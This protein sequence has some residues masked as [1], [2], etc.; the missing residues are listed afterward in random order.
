MTT[1]FQYPAFYNRY[2]IIKAL[3]MVNPR[4]FGLEMFRFPMESLHHYVSYDEEHSLPDPSFKFYQ[5]TTGKILLDHVSDLQSDQGKPRKLALQKLNLVRGFHTKNSNVFRFVEAHF[6][7]K[8]PPQ[9]LEVLNYGLLNR[10]Y[11]YPKNPYAE[12]QR[13]H[14][15]NKTV[16]DKI[17][18]V[19]QTSSRNNFL[20]YEV[21]TVL[22]SL[23]ALNTAKKT[24]TPRTMLIL[25]SPEKLLLLDIWKW[26][27][28]DFSEMSPISAISKDHLSKVN[29]I[30]NFNN[31]WTVLNLGRL[32][33]WR[34]AGDNKTGLKPAD[35]Q[36]FFLRLLLG[37]SI[38]GAVKEKPVEGFDSNVVDD[39]RLNPEL[40]VSD[41]ETH[42]P[43]E[44]GNDSL[45]SEIDKDLS[46]LEELEEKH[47][48]NK[49]TI[50]ESDELA[51]DDFFTKP[52]S[53]EEHAELTKSIFGYKEPENRLVEK[54]DRIADL[55]I[56]SAGD[57]RAAKKQVEKVSSI[58]N[59]FTKGKSIV[60]FS[61]IAK[62]ELELDTAKTKING[63][64][65]LRDQSMTESSLRSF[66]S[67]YIEKV[68]NKDIAG[69]ILNI[70]NSGVMILNH[71][72]ETTNSVLGGYVNHT[73]HIKPLEGVSSVIRFRLPV[74]SDDGTYKLSGNKCYMRKQ[75]G[76]LPIRKMSP[77]SVALTSYYGKVFV[78]RST[79]KV[80]DTYDWLARKIVG[81][82]ETTDSKHI[83][84]YY[85]ANV[86]DNK[87]QLPKVYSSLAMHFKALKFNNMTIEFDRNERYETSL[88]HPAAPLF[89]CGINN[90][91]EFILVGTDNNFYT[92]RNNKLEPLG[93]IFNICLIDRVLAPVETANINIY[94]KKVPLGIA[95]GYYLGLHKLIRLLKC[96]IRVVGRRE[97][98]NL[99]QN[100]YEIVFNDK[101]IIADRN[102]ATTSLLLS[103]FDQYKNT[104]KGYKLSEF[105]S[106]NIYLNLLES[107]GLSTRIIRE[108]DTLDDLFV[109]PITKDILKEMSEPE[110]FIGLL[111]RSAELLTTDYHPDE[112]GM[113]HMRI[114]GYERFAG[115][116]YKE[117]VTSIKEF[118][119][120]G[121]RG[122]TG[123][124][125]NPHAVLMTVARDQSASICQDINPIN[126]LKEQEAVTFAGEGG[127]SKETMTRPTR[128]FDPSDCDII[129]EASVDSSD[130][131]INSFMSNNPQFSSLR[132][133]AKKSSDEFKPGNRLSMSVLAA[134]G[135]DTDDS[136]RVMFISI[137]QSHTIACEGYRQP[138]IRTGAES[139]IARR[140]NKMF[141]YAARQD[142]EV[143][144]VDDKGIIVKYVDN[145]SVGVELGTVFGRAE[146]T[147]YPH[148]I[149]TLMK[150]GV[151]F[152]KDDVIAYNSGFFEEDFMRPG[153]IIMKSSLVVNTVIMEAPE[154]LED[155]SGISREFS[156][157]LN[158]KI[159]KEI[160]A[161]LDFKQGLSKVMKPGTQLKPTDILFIVEE[162]TTA[163][164]DLLDEKSMETLA[165]VTNKAPKAKVYGLLEKIEVYYNGDKED[166]SS[167]LR[168]L[169]DAS[170]RELK[171]KCKSTGEAVVTGAVTE[172]YRVSG[173]PLTLDKA[174]VRVYITVERSS[175]V[176]DKGVFVN[177][178]KTTHSEVFDFSM[179]TEA[180]AKIDAKFGAIPIAARIVNSPD[181]QGTT[182]T[183]LDVGLDRA[184]DIYDGK[185]K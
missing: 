72:V 80:D 6:S 114:K 65:N 70:Q 94:G 83:L 27:D 41:E 170:D 121:L 36:R 49:L 5:G 148:K 181:I 93:D 122:R 44:S 84:K 173:T 17:A 176:G 52:I 164:T 109:D 172:E 96:K 89:H 115:A 20:V 155:A 30:I 168:I 141:A 146:G 131:G 105:E 59:A 103:G 102:D 88:N 74:L 38:S 37:V 51:G 100:E 175:G 135:A 90:K 23:A 39:G 101:K 127:R 161:V 128:K 9:V 19:C 10:M 182:L 14:N 2:G 123:I 40:P 29:L 171:A 55:G 154:T 28:A 16:F 43:D 13:I 158:T 21:P 99:T 159:T 95:L 112:L 60:E 34:R 153:N 142:G 7:L 53:E 4:L 18:E 86:F 125:M 139:V 117:L 180:G 138:Q 47:L 87:A 33:S 134:P 22:P 183:I 61:K 85:P 163:G 113:E 50:K 156:A 57:Y 66:D 132:G 104:V 31:S 8:E 67:D 145:T 98:S 130:V 63:L 119:A 25:D 126:N 157:K 54:L 92:L 3:Q 107:A 120:K 133:L 166:M 71:E 140:T 165:K 106:K 68:L 64:E 42:T 58:K 177:Q 179:R 32:Y 97:R 184:L 24:I 144:S 160:T 79:K 149:K 136:K 151:R 167:S 110:T 45:M 82:V 11:V 26:L 91:K 56:M 35:L 1:Q 76:E 147:I 143:V 46:V 152:K 116:V 12:Y 137:Q 75:K 124:E 77:I 129:S 108:L 162:E 81:I 111:I 185:V 69:M 174:V 62:E 118:K 73:L 78:E 178:L 169:T 150:P 48:R 15:L